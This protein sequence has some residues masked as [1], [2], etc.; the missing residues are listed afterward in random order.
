MTVRRFF[1][2]MVFIVVTIMVS[3]ACYTLLKHPPVGTVPT[4]EVAA[5]PCTSCHYED[6]I[7]GYH[8][9]P[10]HHGYT[11]ENYNDNW[12]YFYMVP[13]WYDSYWYYTPSGPATVPLNER[14]MR[15]AAGTS[16]GG[17]SGGSITGSP[18]PKTGSGAPITVKDSN[19]TR[20]GNTNDS[21]SKNRAV[22]P[23]RKKAKGDGKK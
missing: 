2:P 20:K 17:V 19:D 11:A 16:M 3:P 23:E 21:K 6:E 18:V 22:R 15:P 13:W 1:H 4:E 12:A 7:W 9:P 8:N 14:G 10:N 5:S